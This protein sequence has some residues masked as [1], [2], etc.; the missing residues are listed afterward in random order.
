VHQGYLQRNHEQTADLHRALRK[1]WG[2]RSLIHRST[3]SKS[4]IPMARDGCRRRCW[5]HERQQP[6][7]FGVKLNSKP[8][9]LTIT[10]V[11][12]F[13]RCLALL[14]HSRIPP[15]SKCGRILHFEQ[16]HTRRSNDPRDRRHNKGNLARR[17]TS[18]CQTK[19]T[20]IHRKANL[21][22]QVTTTGLV[23]KEVLGSYLVVLNRRL[24][25]LRNFRH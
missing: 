16:P 12:S 15:L 19:E 2:T 20:K 25:I 10:I 17:R 14:R 18:N 21:V 3:S 23:G 22:A 11:G 1:Q 4:E 7:V 8:F 9:I 6:R 24:A 5:P 13:H